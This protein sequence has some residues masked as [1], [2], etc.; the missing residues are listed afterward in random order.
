MKIEEDRLLKYTVNSLVFIN[1]N[2]MISTNTAQ[3]QFAPAQAQALQRD[4]I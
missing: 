2:H 1:L 4:L 3:C